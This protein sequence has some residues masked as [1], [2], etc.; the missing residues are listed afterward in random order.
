MVLLFGGDKLKIDTQKFSVEYKKPFT[1]TC[2][3]FSDV[4]PDDTVSLD[5][6][7][8]IFRI[9]EIPDT[10]DVTDMYG[11]FSNCRLLTHINLSSL[12]TSNVTNMG[13]MFLFC[14]GLT[15][16]DVSSFDTSKVILYCIILNV[17][18]L[19]I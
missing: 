2:F 16:L 10:S 1:S 19:S 6:I 5:Y 14:S 3:M 8:T 13:N 12:N 7:S 17:E 9:D 4:G 11:M 18:K 15:S